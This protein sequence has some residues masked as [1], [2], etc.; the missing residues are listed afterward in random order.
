MKI[1]IF[2]PNC[3]RALKYSLISGCK[4]LMKS[5]QSIMTEF[6]QY[7]VLKESV[8]VKLTRK[9]S[10]PDVEKIKKDLRTEVE[11]DY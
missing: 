6:S 11:A 1:H 5:F 10:R 2:T 3:S 9:L 7:N 8:R 4:R